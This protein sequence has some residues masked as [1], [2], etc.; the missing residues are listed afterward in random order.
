MKNL[1]RISI[2]ILTLSIFISCKRDNSTK[3]TSLQIPTEYV[4]ANYEANVASENSIR[5]Q[6]GTLT[7]Y[8]KKGEKVDFKLDI[9]MLNNLLNGGTPSISSITQ[10]SFKTLITNSLFP[11]LVVCSQNIY[12]PLLGA[13]ADNGGVFGG[14]LLDKR[15]KETLQ[16]IDK[17][18]YE[19]AAYNHLVHL[20]ESNITQETIDKMICIYG[21]HPNFPNTNTITKTSTPDGLLALYAARRDKK[22]GT[23]YYTKIQQEFLKL[24]AA[25]KAGEAYNQ[26]RDKS[27]AEIKLLIEKSIMAT[28]IHYGF[29]AITKLSS[30]SPSNTTISGGLHDLGE[31]VGF[32]LGF[33]SVPQ[34]QRKITDTQIDEILNLLLAPADADASMYKFV[35]NGETELPKI[36]LMQQKIKAIYGFTDSE[37]NDFKNNWIAVNNR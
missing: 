30:T 35:T 4:S 29:A 8:M 2:F 22:D 24:Q 32:A 1:K 25:V 16:V 36:T 10:P 11:T 37:M 28:V 27:V 31:N 15:A 13:D 14:R 3:K 21:A 9:D 17:G 12:D 18:L 19:A 5:T 23:G 34:P 26:D 6:L 20:T 7:T 33:K